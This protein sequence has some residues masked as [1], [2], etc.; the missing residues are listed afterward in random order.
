VSS[1]QVVV[2]EEAERDI[3]QSFLWYQQRSPA[4]A[5]AFRREVVDAID[6]IARAPRNWRVDDEGNRRLVLHRFPFTIVY[7]VTRD[8]VHILA[9]A[10][11]KKRP[12]YWLGKQ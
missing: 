12:G 2:A 6:R 7:E 4:A 11:H 10:H 8:A 9:V 1:L 5:E 3:T